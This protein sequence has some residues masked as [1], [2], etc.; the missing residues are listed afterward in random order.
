[1]LFYAYSEVYSIFL[2]FMPPWH[3]NGTACQGGVTSFSE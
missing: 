3:W 2:A 1:M